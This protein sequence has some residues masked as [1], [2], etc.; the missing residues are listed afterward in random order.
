KKLIAL[1]QNEPAL[2]I[3]SYRTLHHDLQVIAFIREWEGHDSFVTILNLT[4][5]SYVW[6][7]TEIK[8]EGVV[9]VATHLALEGKTIDG[10]FVLY[11]DE[12]V[13]IRLKNK[14]ADDRSKI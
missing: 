12:G 8:I 10:P 13:V 6:E 5:R 9:E 7:D 11:G 3:G 4:H 2:M 1:R 14:L